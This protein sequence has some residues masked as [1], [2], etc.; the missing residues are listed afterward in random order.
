MKPISYFTSP[1]FPRFI[2]EKRVDK[3]KP[4]LQHA[5]FSES[6]ARSLGTNLPRFDQTDWSRKESEII[7]KNSPWNQFRLPTTFIR[8][9]SS[10][11]W[12]PRNQ[13]KRILYNCGS[14]LTL[15]CH[16]KYCSP[17]LLIAILCI[18]EK[19]HVVL[20]SHIS[21][22]S[23]VQASRN[24]SDLNSRWPLWKP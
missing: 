3:S 12:Y 6:H 4:I 15:V 21:S 17:Y 11:H 16:E 2:L 20:Q 18:E 1:I 24:H 9:L 19:P 13:L 8:F 7:G 14:C 23:S 22:I 10:D 5:D